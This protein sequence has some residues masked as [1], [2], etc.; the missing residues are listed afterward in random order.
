MRDTLHTPFT[1]PLSLD[2]LHIILYCDELRYG[3]IASRTVT[4]RRLG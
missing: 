2:P 4:R 3:S 1:I